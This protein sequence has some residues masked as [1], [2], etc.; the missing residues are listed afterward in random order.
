MDNKQT[1]YERIKNMSVEELAEFLDDMQ[2][3]ALFLEGT[4]NDLKYPTDWKEY[5]ES[6]VEGE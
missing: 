1:N 6:E 5:L 4:I 2:T 3:D